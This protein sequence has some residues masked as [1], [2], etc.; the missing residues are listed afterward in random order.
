MKIIPYFIIALF[1]AV[2]VVFGIAVSTILGISNPDEIDWGNDPNDVP[3]Y[4]V[5]ENCRETGDM[6]FIAEVT[7]NYSTTP[8]DYN[9]S[10]AFLFELLDTDN[11]TTLLSKPLQSFG[12]RPISIYQTA[13]QV[14]AA[15]LT[16]GSNYTLR[17]TGNPTIFATG[18]NNTI[19]VG[20]AE[21]NY[22]D[23]SVATDEANPLRNF[24]INMAE[25]MEDYDDAEGDYITTIQGVRYLT[26]AGGSL[27]LQ[28]VPGLDTLCPILFS[29]GSIQMSSDAPESTGAY[30][31]VFTPLSQWG[32]TTSNGLTA[33][34]EFLG[35]NQALAGS[36]VLFTLVIMLAWYVYSRTQSGITVVLMIGATPFMGAWL[37]LM[38]M[39]LAFILVIFIVILLGYFFFSRGAL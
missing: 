39:A 11:T 30:A 12:D 14:T 9:A 7:C 19:Y 3:T 26:T 38:P 4:R 15:N 1:V 21:S 36:V 35:I 29:S 28:G 33:I 37:G 27:F 16:S 13:S 25:N 24:C 34:G 20:L 23:Q 10:E 32:T 31:A 17:M 5:F 8:T 6:L 2:V 18:T 22:I